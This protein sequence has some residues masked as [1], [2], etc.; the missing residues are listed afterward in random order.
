MTQFKPKASRRGRW[1]IWLAL[2]IV[3]VVVIIVMTPWNITRLAS[4]PDP[5]QTYAEALARVESLRAGAPAG[6]NPVC[7]V[8]LLTHGQK[9]DR[10]IILVHGYTNCPKQMEGI[11][12]RFYDLGYNVLIAPLPY[13]GHGLGDEVVMMGISMGGVT[14]AWAAQNRSDIDLA[15]II[16]PMFGFKQVPTPLTAG[17]MNIY[18]LLPDT[19][20]W[21][22][23][24]QKESAP[25][26]YAYPRYSQHA[27]AQGLRLGFAVQKEARRVAPAAKKLLVVTNAN[28]ESVNNPLTRD[29]VK[30]W[31]AHGA[32]LATYEFEAGLMLEH[33]IFIPD[34]PMIETVYIRLTAL[35]NE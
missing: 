8:Q 4:H 26:S 34:N 32:N 16:S 30:A 9:A 5:A 7:Q 11:G 35:V 25:P 14:T 28:D 13:H 31:Q 3:L 21:W 20:V 15:V 19:F 12:Q 24:V 18:S 17:F 27:L 29:V 2:V 10:A 6:M 1:I 33:D 22:D 23:T